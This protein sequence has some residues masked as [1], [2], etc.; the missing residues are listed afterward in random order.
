[1]ITGLMFFDLSPSVYMR[2]PQLT[3]HYGQVLRCSV[4]RERMKLLTLATALGA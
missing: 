2:S 1:M 3:E 4:V